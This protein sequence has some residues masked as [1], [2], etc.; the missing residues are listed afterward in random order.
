MRHATKA[1]VVVEAIL[2]LIGVALLGKACMESASTY[3]FT[4]F[5]DHAD[6]VI[7]A[8]TDHG[9]RANIEFTDMRG[10]GMVFSQPGL[11]F[12]TQIGQHV[13]VAYDPDN[14]ASASVNTLSALWFKAV[15]GAAP[16]LL[17]LFFGLRMRA[18]RNI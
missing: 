17:F 14:P 10:S 4:G 1:G 12:N 7:N 13:P 3:K 5:A 15:A 8:I 9:L 18:A 11:F 2:I 6:G 16:G